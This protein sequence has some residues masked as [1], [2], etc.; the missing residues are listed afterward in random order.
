MVAYFDKLFLEILSVL[1]RSRW[2][3]T[4]ARSTPQ[5]NVT[6]VKDDTGHQIL[7][8]CS[9]GDAVE[10]H[11]IGGSD[12]ALTNPGV[13]LLF[14][15]VYTCQHLPPEFLGLYLRTVSSATRPKALLSPTVT[16]L[17]VKLLGRLGDLNKGHSS[18]LFYTSKALRIYSVLYVLLSLSIRTLFLIYTPI[19]RH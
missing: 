11:R 4:V 3:Y 5:V 7:V 1:G 19:L 6:L 16:L 8:V 15:L 17:Q 12:S 10:S 18:S 13:F 2:V 14:A 9:R